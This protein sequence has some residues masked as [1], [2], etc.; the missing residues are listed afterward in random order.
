[1]SW[2]ILFV[3][4]T[5]FHCVQSQNIECL[6]AY[7]CASDTG[8]C[9]G[10]DINCVGYRSCMDITIS[11]NWGLDCNGLASCY[12]GELRA[13]GDLYCHSA[14]ACALGSQAIIA[15]NIWVLFCQ[16][17][18]SCVGNNYLDSGASYGG[19]CIGEASCA[20]SNIYSTDDLYAHGALA[21]YYSKIYSNGIDMNIISAGFYTGYK[22]QVF[23]NTGDTCTIFCYG[24]GCFDMN[25]TCE[26]GA[27]CVIKCNDTINN[28]CPNS[29]YS[30]YYSMDVNYLINNV[31]DKIYNSTMRYFFNHG[32][33]LYSTSYPNSNLLDYSNTSINLLTQN[34][35][36]PAAINYQQ[37]FNFTNNLISINNG[38]FCCLAAYS[39]WYLKVE[40]Y[41]T[42]NDLL[43]IGGFSCQYS[44]IVVE[45]GDIYSSYHALDY[46]SVT[47]NNRLYCRAPRSC[48]LVYINGTTV[49]NVNINSKSSLIIT[50]QHAATRSQIFNVKTIYAMSSRA[51]E[52]SN[53]TN[54]R[55]ENMTIYLLSY[56]ASYQTTI[57]CIGNADTFCKIYCTNPNCATTTNSI[58]IDDHEENEANCLW[59]N[60]NVSRTSPIYTEYLLSSKL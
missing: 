44:T 12:L 17:E 31:F 33:E 32:N 42:T 9:T 25:I 49:D 1:M 53:I 28:A 3:V 47:F 30:D 29:I 54:K 50:G 22:S 40:I 24:N 20:F 37:Y 51:L 27:T 11:C 21:L 4:W 16:A 5:A 41:N 19:N 34:C 15:S 52:Y 23:C 2:L 14:W 39:C 35:A 56:E 7:E 60:I 38:S 57:Y 26:S 48:D 6:N 59:I 45:E 10:G 55:N 43:C 46:S 8:L 58:C 18:Y 13:G 36:I